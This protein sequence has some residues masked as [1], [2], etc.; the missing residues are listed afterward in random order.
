MEDQ[1]NLPKWK[2]D[3]LF[4]NFVKLKTCKTASTIFFVELFA[5]RDLI[6]DYSPRKDSLILYKYL[7]KNPL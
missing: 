4:P 1:Q 3:A 5:V 2:D 7:M 6:R